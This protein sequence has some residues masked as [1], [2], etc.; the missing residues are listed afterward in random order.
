M[1]RENGSLVTYVTP[2][3]IYKFLQTS[4]FNG[5]TKINRFQIYYYKDGQGIY[6]ENTDDNELFG[7]GWSKSSDKE[8]VGLWSNHLYLYRYVEKN[9][10]YYI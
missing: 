8:V 4:D 5:L 1:L 7:R 10:L 9:M 2:R 3:R 6:L